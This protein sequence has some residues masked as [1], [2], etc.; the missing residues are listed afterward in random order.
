[1]TDAERLQDAIGLLPEEL[2]S[3]VDTLRR[4]KRFSWKPI[5]TIAASLLL[6]V[7]LYQL[8]PPQKAADRGA[9]LEDAVE[10]GKADGFVG[11][12]AEYSTTLSGY[13]LTAKVAEVA[14]DYLIV[15]L[16]KGETATV[17]FDEMKERKTFSPGAE[18]TLLFAREPEDFTELYPT[19]IMIIYN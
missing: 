1:M 13:F 11:S 9:F 6:V 5:A 16:E 3:P 10:N 4:K 7:G 19:D 17:L 15:T 14:E 12:W 8:Q 2:L 18:I